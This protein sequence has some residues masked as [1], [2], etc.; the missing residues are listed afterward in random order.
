VYPQSSGQ[1]KAKVLSPPLK[2]VSAEQYQGI[3]GADIVFP[4]AGVYELEISGTPKDGS[5]FR[6]FKLTYTVTVA[7]N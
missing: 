5:Q 4:S 2:A 3:P 1:Q 7:G 6:P